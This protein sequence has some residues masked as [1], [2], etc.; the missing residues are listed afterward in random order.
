LI[1]VANIPRMSAASVH[2]QAMDGRQQMK[3]AFG[4]KRPAQI[5]T[6]HDRRDLPSHFDES[7]SSSFDESNVP[8]QVKTTMH[9]VD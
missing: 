8:S 4:A 9:Q 3:M 7:G 2:V 5:R 6:V 1:I